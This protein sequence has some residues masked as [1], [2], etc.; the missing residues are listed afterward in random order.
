MNERLK[1][2][3]TEAM[4]QMVSGP[5]LEQFNQ[6]IIQDCIRTLRSNGYDDAAQCLQDTHFGIEH[7]V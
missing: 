7:P 5:R 6:L 1:K 4:I 3:A 2:L